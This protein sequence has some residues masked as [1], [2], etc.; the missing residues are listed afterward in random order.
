MENTM[1]FHT[2]I[3]EN[4][5]KKSP[6]LAIFFMVIHIILFLPGISNAVTL[7]ELEN[8]ILDHAPY[9]SN[10]DLN[11]DGHVNV[12]DILAFLKEHVAEGPTDLPGYVWAISAS[13]TS[14]NG[15]PIPVNYPFAI[16]IDQYS[17]TCTTIPG[18]DPTKGIL[19]QDIAGPG[20]ISGSKR[21][22]YL[23]SRVVPE[24]T[25]FTF[26]NTE[27]T[28]TLISDSVII[29]ADDPK[30]PVGVELLRTWTI[31]IDKTQLYSGGR[32]HGWITEETFG[33]LPGAEAITAMGPIYMVPFSPTDLL[34]IEA[35]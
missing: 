27:T 11:T 34:P 9:D 26:S 17:G 5:R 23:L 19:R 32:S 1:H 13:F 4:H 7:E 12:A 31:E 24:G 29:S 2:C 35:P 21:P 20:E 8:A 18:F 14:I 16:R 3:I 28:A 10:L 22:S 6:F 25:N 33:F 30:N 15:I